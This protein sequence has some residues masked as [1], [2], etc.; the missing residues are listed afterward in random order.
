MV[1]PHC[2]WLRSHS[3]KT[4]FK[5]YYHWSLPWKVLDPV[6]EF[7]TYTVS[8]RSTQDPI[9]SLLESTQCMVVIHWRRWWWH[10]TL[11]VSSGLLVKRKQQRKTIA[12]LLVTVIYTLSVANDSNEQVHCSL[13][14]QS[15]LLYVIWVQ[16]VASSAPERELPGEA[17]PWPVRQTSKR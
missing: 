12:A 9:S 10:C 16:K 6:L 17:K 14:T 7:Q 3:H 11:T 8:T 5:K 4:K 13:R 15:S 2:Y 1:Y